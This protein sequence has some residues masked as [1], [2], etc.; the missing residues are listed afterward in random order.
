M[1][2]TVESID[3]SGK[4]IIRYPDGSWAEFML[5]DGMT[6][7]DLDHLAYQFRPKTGAVPSFLTEGDSRTAAERVDNAPSQPADP[8]WLANRKEEYGTAIYQLEYIVEN[9]L[10]AWQAE[11]AKIKAKYPK[12]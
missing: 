2:Y 8:E 9:G 4:A 11:V 7:E 10:D 12:T 3:S 1:N 5:E 6:E